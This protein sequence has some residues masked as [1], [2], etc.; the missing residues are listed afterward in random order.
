MGVRPYWKG[1][2]KPSLVT[3]PVQMMPANSENEK[4]RFHTLNRKTQNRA[5]SHNVGSVTGNEVRQEDEVKGYRAART[6]TSS[7]RMRSS[8]MSRSTAPRPSTS[9][10]LPRV[11]RS[12]GSRSTPRTICLRTIRSARRLSRHS[13]RYEI[14]GYGWH[15]ATGHHA[16][17]VRRHAGAARQ[18]Y[19][20][21]NLRYGDEVMPYQTQSE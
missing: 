20:S 18:G 12:S 17:R 15:F 6:N 11:K 5:V 8:K 7:S 3:C 14:L 13:R 9:P 10:S 1:Y 2:L 16:A 4:I 21:A 19:R